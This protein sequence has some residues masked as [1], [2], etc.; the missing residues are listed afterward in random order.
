MSVNMFPLRRYERR[1][2]KP[3][4]AARFKK[5]KQLPPNPQGTIS[6]WNF[7]L[8]TLPMLRPSRAS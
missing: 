4:L 3:Q 5:A 7:S 6:P 2:Y 1:V 8:N